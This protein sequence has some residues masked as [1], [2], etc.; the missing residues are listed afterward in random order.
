MGLERLLAPLETT[1][2][3]RDNRYSILRW[4]LAGKPY[5]SDAEI[6][7]P[8]HHTW[9]SVDACSQMHRWAM[10]VYYSALPDDICTTILDGVVSF[11]PHELLVR[12]RSSVL[13]NYTYTWE[14]EK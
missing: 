8:I 12:W 3:W 6:H 11:S 13:G 2:D 7:C 10:M 9:E 5:L 14:A 1:P 4:M